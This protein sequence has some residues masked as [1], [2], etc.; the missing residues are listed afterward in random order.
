MTETAR[1]TYSD[2]VLSYQIGEN[3]K[4][5]TTD[6]ATLITNFFKQAFMARNKA[7]T[8]DSD[9]V[10]DTPECYMIILSE[11]QR[12]IEAW[13]SALKMQSQTQMPTLFLSKDAINQI[14]QLVGQ[15]LTSTQPL[16]D[17][18]R[19]WGYDEDYQ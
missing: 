13:A 19:M 17:N 6:A 10:I 1:P 8:T 7:Y 2:L 3:T 9:N 18:A 14:K 5:N 12:V 4:P 16:I 15:N 11:V